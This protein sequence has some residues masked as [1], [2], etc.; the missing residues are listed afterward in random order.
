MTADATAL[1]QAADGL[2][3][4]ARVHKRSAAAHRQ[5][6]RNLMQKAEELEAV[7]RAAGI[8]IQYHDKAERAQSSDEHR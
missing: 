7:C 3:A 1:A 8:Q 4:A 5:E 6:A 2:R